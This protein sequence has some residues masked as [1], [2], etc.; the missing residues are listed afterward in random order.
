MLEKYVMENIDRFP[1]GGFTG[2]TKIC[3]P[4]DSLDESNLIQAL[5]KALPVHA[6]NAAQIDYLYRVYKGEQDVRWKTKQTRPEVNNKV[7]VNHANEIVTFK[8]AFLLSG[9]IQYTA[10]NSGIS[11]SVSESVN[12]LNE[13]MRMESKESKDKTLVNWV[14]IGGIC[15]RI[16]M[17]VPGA[18]RYGAPFRIGVPDP[19]KAF[20]I[21]NSDIWEDQIAGVALAR[22]VDENVV[23]N[24]YTDKWYFRVK[25]GKILQ[26]SPHIMGEIP[27]I[28]YVNNDARLGAFEIVLPILNAINTLESNAVDNVQ[29]F[30]NAY[31][32][33][34]NCEI[35]TEKY[36]QLTAGGGAVSVK[37]V[38][39]GNDVRVYRIA[40][41]LN[42]TNVQTRIDSFTEDYLT[43]CG[44]PNR[45]GGLSTSDTGQAVIFRDGWSEAESR[46]KDTETSFVEPESKF[47]KIALNICRN[48]TGMVLDPEDI[49]IDFLR[50]NLSNIDVKV[51]VLT[52]L[53]NNPKVHPKL[54]FEA[55]S[56]LF[57]DTEAAYRESMSYFEEQKREQEEALE[58]ELDDA[59]TQALRAG[60][61]RNSET[62]QAGNSQSESDVG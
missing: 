40:S 1:P 33:F 50:K 2:R 3:V 48:K 36:R 20:A 43:I 12:Q 41:E 8:T 51:N 6:K 59:R 25:N 34:Q 14:H 58:K 38:N 17:P 4:F 18:F 28:E 22:D 53:L 57:R 30:V 42:P 46:A 54:A 5:E 7:C 23:L 31:D 21:Y 55:A 37:S 52:T 56:G 24:V 27:I 62:E 26:K 15:P 39:G 45:N 11:D 19:R 47:V 13:F 29:D 16:I 35:E 49:Q 44:M 61:Q 10:H 9:P 32:V 60:G